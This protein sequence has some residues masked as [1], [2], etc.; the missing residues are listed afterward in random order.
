VIAIVI[1]QRSKSNC[2]HCLACLAKMHTN[3]R[4]RAQSRSAE[5]LPMLPMLP[6]ATRMMPR[7]LSW[8]VASPR[9][10]L[11]AQWVSFWLRPKWVTRYVLAPETHSPFVRLSAGSDGSK[12]KLIKEQLFA[13]LR[14]F[15]WY[16]MPWNV[17]YR[18]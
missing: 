13:E 1:S 16:K 12:L 14:V 18:I 4:G 3:I 9:L 10:C 15:T 11:H 2:L 5:M 8:Q 7:A 17:C 6:H